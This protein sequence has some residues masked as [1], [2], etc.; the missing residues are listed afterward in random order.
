M[1]QTLYAQWEA[2]V[3]QDAGRRAAEGVFQRAQRA[4]VAEH[5]KTVVD[6]PGW[7]VFL[8]HLEALVAARTKEKERSIEELL[9]AVG[10]KVEGLRLSIQALDGELKGLKLACALIPGLIETGRIAAG[11][12]PADIAERRGST[13]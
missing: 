9:T 2:G 3:R 13:T 6:H 10:T 1:S 11:S 4:Q 7:Q 5:A 8:N 12:P